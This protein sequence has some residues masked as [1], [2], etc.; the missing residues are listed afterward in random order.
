[1]AT[2]RALRACTV[3]AVPLLVA[4]GCAGPQPAAESVRPVSDASP[5]TPTSSPPPSTSSIPSTTARPTPTAA[6]TPTSA[7]KPAPPPAPKP[8][9]D[10]APTTTRPA[11]PTAEPAPQAEEQPSGCNDNY[12]PCVPDD[13]TDVDC[14]GGSGNGPS[15]VEGPVQVIGDDVY[16]LDRDGNGEGCE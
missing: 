10:P 12:D 9:A 1:M 8:P 14:A 3:L 7:P 15:Y 2:S 6:P 4:L 13:P 16:G 5:A 11:A